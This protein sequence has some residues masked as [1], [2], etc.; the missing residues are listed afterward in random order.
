MT[1]TLY[2]LSIDD[3]AGIDQAV[4]PGPGGPTPRPDVHPVPSGTHLLFAQ[5]GKIERV[6]LDGYD[7]QQEEAKPLLYLPVR[8]LQ[9]SIRLN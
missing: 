2:T 7:M 5:S 9:I 4:T 8:R 3:L 6:P 1:Y